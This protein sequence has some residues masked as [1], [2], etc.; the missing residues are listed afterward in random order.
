VVEVVYERCCG[1]DI[2]KQTIVACLLVPGPGKGPRK[3]VRT[4]GTMTDELL[5]RA[6][7]GGRRRRWSRSS[8]PI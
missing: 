1:L 5:L 7:A 8:E 4:F 6:W 3:E 2:H